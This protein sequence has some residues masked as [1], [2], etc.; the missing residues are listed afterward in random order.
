MTVMEDLTLSHC[1]KEFFDH[2][3][4]CFLKDN[5]SWFLGIFESHKV[6]AEIIEGNMG[7]HQIRSR[8]QF[9]LHEGFSL[10]MYFM[11]VLH[12]KPRE[13]K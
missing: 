11:Q 7:F 8:S 2:P 4:L 13:A 6:L 10:F 3:A 9:S 5:M 12:I 1:F